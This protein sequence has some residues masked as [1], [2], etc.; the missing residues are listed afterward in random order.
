[1]AIQTATK[2]AE[3]QKYGYV[4]YKDSDKMSSKK[5]WNCMISGFFGGFIVG[6]FGIGSSIVLEPVWI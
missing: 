5:M 2:D 4:F 1:M 6:L 3:K